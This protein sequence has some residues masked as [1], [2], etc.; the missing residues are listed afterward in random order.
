PQASGDRARLL[1]D[2]GAMAEL[3]AQHGKRIAYEALAW[4]P[5]VNDHRDAWGLVRDVDHS[6]LGMALDSFH[7]LSRGIPSSSI[8]D[9]RA[10]KLFIVQL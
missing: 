8:A 4:A 3:A 7:S 9:I 6:A 2:L 1:D 5:H 10:D